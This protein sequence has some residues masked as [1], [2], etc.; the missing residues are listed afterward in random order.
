MTAMTTTAT[1]T[2][3]A[4]SHERN[5]PPRQPQAAIA[6][7]PT[8]AR[9]TKRAKASAS[10]GMNRTA[11]ATSAGGCNCGSH[12]VGAHRVGA[13]GGLVDIGH[14]GGAAQGGGRFGLRGVG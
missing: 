10:A 2:A 13:A 6:A 5:T 11:Y 7:R 14:G 9:K 3:G 8:R 12:E 1:P 4:S